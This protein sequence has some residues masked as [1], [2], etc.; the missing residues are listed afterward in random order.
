MTKK[1]RPVTILNSM[2]KV[3]KRVVNSQLK[4]YLLDHKL[5]SK[6]QHAYQKGKSTTTAWLEIDSLTT[7]GLD[8][9]KLVGYQLMDMSAT[10]NLVDKTI[11]VPKLRMLG[12]SDSFCRLIMSYMSGRT[13]S[14]KIKQYVSVPRQVPTGVGEG[15]VLGPLVFLI[16]I[17]EVTLVQQIVRDRL[18]SE[19]EEIARKVELHSVQFAD[20][21]TNV[22]I[23]EDE[24]QMEVVMKLCSQEYHRYFS[25]QGMKLNVSK[26]EHI[27]H[28]YMPSARVKPGGVIVD[29]R[30]E[31]LK[32][33]LLGMTVDRD[34]SFTTH[35]GKVIAAAS[36]KL[37]HVSKV[38]KYLDDKTL[39]EVT[40]SLVLSVLYWG[41]EL[42]ARDS[43][44]IR[45]L[46]VCQNSILRMMT[47]SPYDMSVRLMLSKTKLYNIENQRRFQMMSLVRRSINQKCCPQTNKYIVMPSDK[48]RSGEIR[49]VFPNNLQHSKS[50]MLVR[51][52]G[53]LNDMRWWKTRGKDGK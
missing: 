16:L 18:K 51:G 6:E 10:F 24:W 35:V 21:C 26:E 36:Y 25:S 15:S 12:C 23:T 32:V 14:V 38:A 31:A 7:S 22:I 50:S 1:W 33:K 5:I 2:S 47:R 39:K 41:L 28:A 11:L 19:H 27:C 45:R 48:S 4:D 29:G 8:R 40:R 37:S 49:N 43:T 17:L 53:L 13:N 3:A 9:R 46:Q 42:A 52:L 44:S 30:P 20:D 34:Y